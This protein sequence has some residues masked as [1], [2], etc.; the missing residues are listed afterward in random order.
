MTSPQNNPRPAP[1]EMSTWF[2]EEQSEDDFMSSLPPKPTQEPAE[3]M[4]WV[5]LVNPPRWELKGTG[6]VL[7]D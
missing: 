6:A 7:K 1:G 3:G 4:I 5:P 2:K